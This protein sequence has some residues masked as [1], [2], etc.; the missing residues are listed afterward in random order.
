VIR[1]RRDHERAEMRDPTR[2]RSLR[3]LFVDETEDDPPPFARDAEPSLALLAQDLSLPEIVSDRELYERA[4]A[5]LRQLSPDEVYAVRRI[6]LEGE[7]VA[8]VARELGLGES[9][10]RQRLVRAL[11]RIG[12]RLGEEFCERFGGNDLA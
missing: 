6:E 7:T 9:T 8:A 10:I 5:A 2:R 1:N 11:A 3:E 12:Q 4:V